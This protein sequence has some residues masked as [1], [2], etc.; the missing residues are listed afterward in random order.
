MRAPVYEREPRC[1]E[2]HEESPGLD[3]S[4]SVAEITS[5]SL[6]V[7]AL[8]VCGGISGDTV[9][10]NCSDRLRVVRSYSG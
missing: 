6:H 7:F 9:R 1:W 10:I 8:F 2:A 5:T 3:S 4:E